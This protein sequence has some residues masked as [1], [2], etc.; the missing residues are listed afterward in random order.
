MVVIK[1][2]GNNG[3]SPATMTSPADAQGVISVAA[4]D[5]LGTTVQDYS[6][7]GPVL[8]RAGPTLAA[9]GG[10]AAGP[11]LVCAL[12]GGG[13]GDAG[14]GTSYAAPQVSGLVALLLEADPALSPDDVRKRLVAGAVALAGGAAAVGAGL[15]HVG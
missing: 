10:D 6:S 8:G 13:F 11:H 1:S 7:R 2:A 5:V 4:T 3:P 9:P 15:A 14:V 12:P